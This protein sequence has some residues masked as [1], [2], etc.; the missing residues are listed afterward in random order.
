MSNTTLHNNIM[1]RIYVIYMLRQLT[2]PR[3]LKVCVLAVVSIALVSFVS[4]S[5]VLANMP[6]YD[7]QAFYDFMLYALLHTDTVVQ[8]FL[9]AAVS[10]LLMLIRD[11]AR[12]AAHFILPRS[13]A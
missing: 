12:G 7:F 3:M 1:R 6:L 4:V 2:D 10:V 11:I 8:L 9:A 13:I 5:D